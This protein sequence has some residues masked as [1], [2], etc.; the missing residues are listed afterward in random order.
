MFFYNY[1]VVRKSPKK[2]LIYIR[3]FF[4]RTC[5][6]TAFPGYLNDLIDADVCIPIHVLHK[7]K[8]NALNFILIKFVLIKKKYRIKMIVSI[9]TE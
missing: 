2:E 4:Y 6:L 9:S 1:Y 8:P 5:F 7:N 3:T